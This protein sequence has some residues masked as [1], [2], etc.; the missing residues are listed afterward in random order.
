MRVS[1]HDVNDGKEK[2]LIVLMVR[3]QDLRYPEILFL[4]RD[5]LSRIKIQLREWDEQ[6]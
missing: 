2:K 4:N 3:Y 5:H 1:H 6:G